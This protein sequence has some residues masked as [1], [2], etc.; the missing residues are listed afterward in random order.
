MAVWTCE[1]FTF[2][3][4]DA[5]FGFVCLFAAAEFATVAG[6]RARAAVEDWLLT[7][8]GR[9]LLFLQATNFCVELG[10]ASRALAQV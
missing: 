9:A 10:A 8:K 2:L 5:A 4:P 3:L 7:L 1:I 6:V